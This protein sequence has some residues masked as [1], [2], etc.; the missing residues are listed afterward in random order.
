MIE[1]L[2]ALAF[3]SSISSFCEVFR[4]SKKRLP[5]RV[6]LEMEREKR[7]RIIERML[8]KPVTDDA[9]REYSPDQRVTS[10]TPP[11]FLVHAHDDGLSVKHSVQF[12]LALQQAEV[13]AELHVYSQG[14]HGFGIRQ[15]GQ[16]ISD[17]P[18]RWLHSR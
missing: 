11:T 12:Y 2:C 5:L 6:S 10:Q 7:A 13:S 17:W 4:Q 14:G 8:G 15:R 3:I 9:V 16:P 18:D 1:F